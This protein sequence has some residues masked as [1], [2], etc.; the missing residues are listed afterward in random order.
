[1]DVLRYQVGPPCMVVTTT[2]GVQLLARIGGDPNNT[3]PW[4]LV[5]DTFSWT[6]VSVTL[7][8]A[9]LSLWVCSAQLGIQYAILKLKSTILFYTRAGDLEC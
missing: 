3:T 8:W 6:V 9:L 5:G 1:M 2:T 7:F 4:S